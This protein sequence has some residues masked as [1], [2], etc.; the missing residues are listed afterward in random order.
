VSEAA[1][2]GTPLEKP[3]ELPEDEVLKPVTVAVRAL[4]GVVGS[5]GSA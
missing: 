5:G 4:L 2:T 1:A 3:L